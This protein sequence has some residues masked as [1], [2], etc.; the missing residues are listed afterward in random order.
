MDGANSTHYFNLGPRL[1]FTFATLIVLILAGNA[2]VVWQ[3]HLT[4]NQTDRLT[5]ANQQLIEVLRL[6]ASLLSFHRRLD[7]LALSMDVRRLDTE[8]ESLRRALHEQTQQ[9]RTA[10]ATLRSGTIVDPSFLPTLDTIDVT[11][12][13]ELEA[14][15]ELA[16]SGDWAVIHPRLGNELNLIE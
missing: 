9:T 7:D 10:I 6:Q 12:P 11:L 2:L 14:I 1:A 4:R 16:K 13:S 15:L 5:G 3:F 8:A